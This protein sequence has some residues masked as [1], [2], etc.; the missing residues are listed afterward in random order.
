MACC[1]MP[2]EVTSLLVVSNRTG[3]IPAD[4]PDD[5]LIWEDMVDLA[6]IVDITVL[7]WLIAWGTKA[8]SATEFADY[9]A[10]W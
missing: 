1:P 2:E 9:P 10:H 4:R 6:A 3:E 8:F 5:E 7:D